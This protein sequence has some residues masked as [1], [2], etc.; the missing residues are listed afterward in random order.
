MRGKGQLWLSIALVA[1]LATSVQAADPDDMVLF[2]AQSGGAIAGLWS[3]TYTA[4]TFGASVPL[5]GGY[6]F[7]NDPGLTPNPNIPRVGDIN[8]D[9]IADLVTIGDN[10]AQVLYQGRNTGGTLFDPP[11]GPVGWPDNFIGTN[12][13]A[14]AHF[15]A[16]VNGDGY[17]D[18]LTMRPAPGNPTMMFWEAYHSDA[19]GIDAT[20]S[21]LSWAAAGNI[22]NQPIVGDFNGDGRADIGHRFEN[23]IDAPDGWMQVS[24]SGPGGVQPVDGAL[25]NFTHGIIEENPNHVAT[26][27][28]DLNGDG[29][30]DV[31]EVDN[32]NSDGSYLWVAGCTGVDAGLPS[33]IG[34]GT[35]TRSFAQPFGTPNAGTTTQVPLLG[36]MN[37]DGLDD[38]VQYWEFPDPSGSG[39]WFGQWLVAYTQPGG[40]LGGFS[41]VL[42][43]PLTTDQIGNIPMIAQFTPEPTTGLMVLLLGLAGLRRRQ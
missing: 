23:G 42:T 43:I 9:G 22:G 2:N 33:G 32:R 36:D 25:T 16:D 20:A 28:G 26:L 15:L 37:G 8:G 1:A 11:I 10:T 30:D 34:I 41:D 12:N 14:Q 27:I 19:D 40:V 24:F 21:S 29:M 13:A 5:D 17:A 6:T 18:P 7:F 38:L 39:G 4:P 35:G 3:L 31:V